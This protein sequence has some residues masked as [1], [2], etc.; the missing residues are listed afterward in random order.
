MSIYN[1]LFA[2]QEKLT[3]C[4]KSTIHDLKKKDHRERDPVIAGPEHFR[5][6]FNNFNLKN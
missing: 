3:Q 2:V 6:L 1:I 4:C 5:K